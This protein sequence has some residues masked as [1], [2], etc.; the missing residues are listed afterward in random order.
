MN[1]L[2]PLI[3]CS[4]RNWL[5]SEIGLI[6]MFIIFFKGHLNIIKSFSKSELKNSNLLLGA[7][8]VSLSYDFRGE[9]SSDPAKS[10]GKVI[11]HP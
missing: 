6:F 10:S 3:R 7:F 1:N 9:R 8:E 2:S 5:C 4:Q 11:C